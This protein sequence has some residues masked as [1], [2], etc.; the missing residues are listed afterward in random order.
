MVPNPKQDARQPGGERWPALS[1]CP[2]L[3]PESTQGQDLLPQW[4]L[5]EV[6]GVC[7]PREWLTSLPKFSKDEV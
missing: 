6:L 4:S 7:G 5:G 1:P 3:T 2:A